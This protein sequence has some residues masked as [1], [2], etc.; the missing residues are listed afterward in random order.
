MMDRLHRVNDPLLTV[1]GNLGFNRP[2]ILKSILEEILR[3]P[4]KSLKNKIKILKETSNK[5]ELIRCPGH[6]HK[7]L[8]IDQN[9]MASRTSVNVGQIKT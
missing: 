4:N 7:T 3:L 6:I 9:P 5:I 1:I 8:K 2:L